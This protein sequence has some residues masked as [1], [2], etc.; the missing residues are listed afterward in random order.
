[1]TDQEIVAKYGHLL[2]NTGGNDPLDLLKRLRTENRLMTTNIV[3]YL[4]A[5]A[6]ESQINLLKRLHDRGMIR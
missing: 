4:L 6:V 5:V 2:G 1:M 3:V